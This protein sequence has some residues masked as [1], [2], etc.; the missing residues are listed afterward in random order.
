MIIDSL[1]KNKDI[2]NLS[3]FNTKAYS[4]YYFE[5][6]SRQDIDSIY[7]IYNYALKNNLKLLFVAWGTN[8]LFAFDIFDWIII[9]NNLSWWTYNSETKILESYSNELISDI[10]ESLLNDSRQV[11][12]KR[13][14]WLPWSIWWA[15]FWNAGCFWLETENNFVE[16]ELLDLETWKRTILD[17][18][19]MKFNYRTSIIKETNKYFIIKI[20][21]DLSKLVEKYSSDVDN[22]Y[23]R[24]HKQPKG[25]TCGSFFKNPSRENS[26]W[27][28]IEEVWLKWNK[29]WWA[30]FSD[31]H[32]NFLMN[33]GTATYTDLLD[34]IKLAQEKVKGTYNVDLVPEVRIIFN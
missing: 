7:E 31:K 8:L 22:L 32:A 25:N 34:L 16:A 30:F 33:D 3:N 23:F 19:E 5:I 20:Q 24:E 17:R 2:S 15:V 12:W 26:A 13:F 11:L 21:F 14:I 29:I 10:S 6:N 27:K 18:E 1:I 4:K 28:L 9:K